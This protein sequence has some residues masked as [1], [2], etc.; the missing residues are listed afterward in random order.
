MSSTPPP[1]EYPPP[2]PDF[3]QVAALV[4]QPPFAAEPHPEAVRSLPVVSAQTFLAALRPK[5]PPP[6][7]PRGKRPVNVVQPHQ[8]GGYTPQDQQPQLSGSIPGNNFP[9]PLQTAPT[10]I[11]KAAFEPKAPLPP[12]QQRQEVSGNGMFQP[13]APPVPVCMPCQPPHPSPQSQPGPQR[14]VEPSAPYA[15]P[16]CSGRSQLAERRVSFRDRSPIRPLDECT[17]LVEYRSSKALADGLVQGARTELVRSWSGVNLND[18]W[19]CTLTGVLN[20]TWG[21]VAMQS[22][23]H[24]NK[25]SGTSKSSIKTASCLGGID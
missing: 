23:G 7:P 15:P 12:P 11:P 6:P 18:Y 4:D 10:S 20:R 21:A 13:P 25:W 22:A 2:E 14:P 16:N 24:L 1:P 5:K 3:T 9:Q 19:Y 8:P 17:A